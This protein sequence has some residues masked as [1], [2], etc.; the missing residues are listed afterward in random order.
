MIHTLS[1]DGPTIVWGVMIGPG[2]LP[3]GCVPAPRC[4][5]APLDL[6]REQHEE[7]LARIGQITERL[8]HAA[9][10]ADSV[11]AKRPP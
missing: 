10:H 3:V 11:Q 7:A 1:A 4:R 8:C 2:D 6:L 5:N 9:R